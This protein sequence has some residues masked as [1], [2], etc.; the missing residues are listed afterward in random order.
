[1]ETAPDQGA[2][3]VHRAAV[4]V[5]GVGTQGGAG[6]GQGECAGLGE[7]SIPQ[8]MSTAALAARAAGTRALT[9]AGRSGSGR[10]LA[11]A[12]AVTSASAWAGRRPTAPMV[13]R[14]DG[15]L[16]DAQAV[17]GQALDEHHRVHVVG[18]GVGR[19][20]ERLGE[21]SFTARRRAPSLPPSPA[22][23]PS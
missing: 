14:A 16:V 11:G 7:Q 1:V 20:D 22:P 12:T 4:V 9:S 19:P 17:V 23:R 18:Q 21:L 15:L 6:L 5:G 8:A 10:R 2:G 13:D 3:R